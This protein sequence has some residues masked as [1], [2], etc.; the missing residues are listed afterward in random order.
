[1]GA[2]VLTGSNFINLITMLVFKGSDA[3]DVEGEKGTSKRQLGRGP[4]LNFQLWLRGSSGTA[5][6]S[7]EQHRKTSAQG[8]MEEIASVSFRLC[9][10]GVT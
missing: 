10:Q 1:M 8:E 6:E 2:L 9:K 5:D 7:D 3:G 4:A